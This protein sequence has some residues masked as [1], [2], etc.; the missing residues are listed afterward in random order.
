MPL[1]FVAGGT[2]TT[3]VVVHF[4]DGVIVEVSSLPGSTPGRP[5]P[6]RIPSLPEKKTKIFESAKHLKTQV[7]LPV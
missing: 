7:V 3:K 5:G 1:S 4:F 6:I 2:A